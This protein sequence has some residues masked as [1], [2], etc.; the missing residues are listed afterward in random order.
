MTKYEFAS[1]LYRD[2]REMLDAIAVQWMSTDVW[3]E[4]PREILSWLTDDLLASE[5]IDG[6]GLSLQSPNAADEDYPSH[7]DENSYSAADLAL[8]F[9]RLRAIMCDRRGHP[10]LTA[11]HGQ[12]S[13]SNSTATGTP[14][15]S[16]AR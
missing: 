14:G 10:H 9:A 11:F 1:R 6:W 12:S 2:K 5:C 15:G 3:T 13:S 7:M 8:A 16:T 4:E